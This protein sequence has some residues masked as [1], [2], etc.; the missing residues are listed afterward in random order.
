M[1]TIFFF[2]HAPLDSGLVFALVVQLHSGLK[3]FLLL[4]R[5]VLHPVHIVA[6]KVLG[7]I[8]D[9]SA[10]A[11]MLEKRVL[12]LDYCNSVSVANS[13]LNALL[14]NFL[15]VVPHFLGNTALAYLFFTLSHFVL[16]DVVD[17]Q[18]EG[19]AVVARELAVDEFRLPLTEVDLLLKLLFRQQ[20]LVE[21]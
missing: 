2:N 13:F 9:F 19:A 18:V 5:V 16:A 1:F 15:E 11:S 20:R 17:T 21:G 14:H 12:L 7:H 8:R 10:T 6:Q 3:F 4:L